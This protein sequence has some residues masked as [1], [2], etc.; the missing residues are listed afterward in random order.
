VPSDADRRLEAGK[1]QMRDWRFLNRM[2]DMMAFTAGVNP[3]HRP[4]GEGPGVRVETPLVSW[5]RVSP[6]S[7]ERGRG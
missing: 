3:S 6:C 5:R 4:S 7:L 1:V 2:G